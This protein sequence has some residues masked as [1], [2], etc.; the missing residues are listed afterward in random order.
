M[1]PQEHG[2]IAAAYMMRM[3]D[4]DLAEIVRDYLQDQGAY[5]G[6]AGEDETGRASF[7]YRPW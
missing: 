7:V 2:N 3:T 5:V 1:T 6:E 4:G